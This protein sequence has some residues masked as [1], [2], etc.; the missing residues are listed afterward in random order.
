M[1]NLTPAACPALT[2]RTGEA[3]HGSAQ[4]HLSIFLLI[5]MWENVPHVKFRIFG[6]V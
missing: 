3:N 5:G 2:N 4:S 6:T 1:A